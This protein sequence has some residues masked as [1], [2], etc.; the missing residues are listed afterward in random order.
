VIP[1]VNDQD[2][3]LSDIASRIVAELGP[4]VPWHVTGY[5]PA[6]RF[7]APPTPVDTLERA[8]HLGKKAGLRFVYLGN[9]SGHQLENTF[10]PDCGR[11]LIE[12]WGLHRTVSHLDNGCCP[13]C[14]HEVPGV[15]K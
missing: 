7:T 12:R 15:W 5:Y 10:C 14:G 4:E 1:G 9:V 13:E 6:Y 2:E 8:W 3:V 11:L